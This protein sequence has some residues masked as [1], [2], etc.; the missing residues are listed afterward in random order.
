MPWANINRNETQLIDQLDISMYLRHSK[1]NQWLIHRARSPPYGE[2][3]KN[4]NLKVIVKLR[5][6]ADLDFDLDLN[7]GI[8]PN[9]VTL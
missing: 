2:G 5:N 6:L 7:W 9:I 4:H 3:R 8:T 1:Q